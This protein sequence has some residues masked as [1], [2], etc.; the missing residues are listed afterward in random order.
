MIAGQYFHEFHWHGDHTGLHLD[1][2]SDEPEDSQLQPVAEVSESVRETGAMYVRG[3]TTSL[4]CHADAFRCCRRL[5]GWSMGS[6]RI[7]AS[8]R[9]RLL[10]WQASPGRGRSIGA[11][12]P[13]VERQVQAVEAACISRT[14]T[15]QQGRSPWQPGLRGNDAVSWKRAGGSVGLEVQGDIAT[16]WRSRRRRPGSTKKPG[17]DGAAPRIRRS[18]RAFC[19]AARDVGA[20]E[21]RAELAT[22]RR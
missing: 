16:C 6:R 22:R 7:T 3:T 12:L 20:V 17:A 19:A 10:G 15:A 18:R 9:R 11:T 5:K 21:A 13:L 4:H 1:V 2:V 8:M 14:A